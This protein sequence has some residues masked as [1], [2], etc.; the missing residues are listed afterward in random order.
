[1]DCKGRG[2]EIKNPHRMRVGIK[3]CWCLYT[4][5]QYLFYMMSVHT[6]YIH[7]QHTH[8]I[9]THY[10]HTHIIAGCIGR[11]CWFRLAKLQNIDF[12]KCDSLLPAHLPLLPPHSSH[13]HT[14]GILSFF[15]VQA[16]ARLV[17]AI[18]AS[19]MAAYCME[20]VKG[21][22]LTNKVVVIAGK[23]EEVW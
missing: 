15:A 17:Y 12:S 13:S 10:T 3:A 22:R 1:M 20:L 18:E 2:M 11:W 21:N 4:E 19:S 8:Y 14:T 9:Q 7:T 5:K 23:I 16:G 6:Y